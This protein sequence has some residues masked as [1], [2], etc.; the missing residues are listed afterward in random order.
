MLGFLYDYNVDYNYIIC[1]L[2]SGDR[3][4]SLRYLRESKLAEICCSSPLF[5]KH[6]LSLQWTSDVTVVSSQEATKWFVTGNY[7]GNTN[8]DTYYI[9]L[10]AIPPL[11]PTISLRSSSA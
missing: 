4:R 2:V 3:L 8:K 1:L 7:N 5:T 11:T 10:Y 9:I 6:V